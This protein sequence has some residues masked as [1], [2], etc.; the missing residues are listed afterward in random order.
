M[1]MEPNEQEIESALLFPAELPLD[2]V[3]AREERGRQI[4]SSKKIHELGLKDEFK[5]EPAVPLIAS[6]Y[7]EEVQ[8]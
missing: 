7:Y 1:L 3:R 5:F 2:E 6:P 8:P 4:A